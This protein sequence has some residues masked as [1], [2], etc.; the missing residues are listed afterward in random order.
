LFILLAVRYGDSV[1]NT[2]EENSSIFSL[3]R[4]HWLPSARASGQSNS[5]PTS[6]PVLNRRC[7]LT[8]ADLYSGCR[9][10]VGSSELGR[11]NMGLLCVSLRY[12]FH[13]CTSN[14]S[15]CYIA[16]TAAIAKTVPIK[17]FS[18]INKWHSV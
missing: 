18:S 1:D 13:F 5:A 6:P 2:V 10:V 7:W 4:M 11:K 14:T 12:S 15:C 3:I 17:Y 16:V 8:Q 9:M